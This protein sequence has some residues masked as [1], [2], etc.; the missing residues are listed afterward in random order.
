MREWGWRNIFTEDEDNHQNLAHDKI[1][2]RYL[3]MTKIVLCLLI[4]L[5]K[6]VINCNKYKK[7]SLTIYVKLGT[8]RIPFHR[9]LFRKT[10]LVLIISSTTQHLRY[11]CL[12]FVLLMRILRG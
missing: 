11:C 5:Y 1:P 2:K 9:T 8:D 10:F 12:T 7:S 3:V 4:E 6:F